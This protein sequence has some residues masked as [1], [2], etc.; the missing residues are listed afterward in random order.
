MEP[1]IREWAPW[2]SSSLIALGGTGIRPLA[3][4]PNAQAKVHVLRRVSSRLTY[5][6]VCPTQ[7]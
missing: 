3:S 1:Q 7:T 4:E 6:S 5:F 2:K